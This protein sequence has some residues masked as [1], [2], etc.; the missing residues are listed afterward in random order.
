MLSYE[1][2]KILHLASIFAFIGLTGHAFLANASTKAQKISSG[3]ASFFI[4]VA[5]MGLLARLGVSHG[6]GFPTWVIVKMV[7][8]LILAAGIPVLSKRLTQGRG[9]AFI[10]V[11]ALASSAHYLALYKP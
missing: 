6:E 9:L 7:I 10:A 5:G 4:L 2:Y 3:I 8:W 1:F 11:L